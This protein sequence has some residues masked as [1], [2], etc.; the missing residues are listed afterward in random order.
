MHLVVVHSHLNLF[1]WSSVYMHWI[2]VKSDC[3]TNISKLYVHFEEGFVI[4]II[5][6]CINT[7]YILF[8]VSVRLFGAVKTIFREKNDFEITKKINDFAIMIV[9]KKRMICKFTVSWSL[10]SMFFVVLLVK[11]NG[12]EIIVHKWFWSMLCV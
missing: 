4:N 1:F 12:C 7:C 8:F 9:T 5:I 11:W 3:N 2:C 10:H 6:L